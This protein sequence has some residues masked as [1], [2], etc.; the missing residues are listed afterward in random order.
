MESRILPPN[1]TL[2]E[3]IIAMQKQLGRTFI[4]MQKFEVLRLEDKNNYYYKVFLTFDNKYV[5]AC[6]NTIAIEHD[7]DREDFGKGMEN[8]FIV[9]KLKRTGTEDF[10]QEIAKSYG[11]KSLLTCLDFDDSANLIGFKINKDKK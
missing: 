10:L 11:L 2:R 3:R 1:N 9:S 7:L 8:G 4:N 6:S 5:V